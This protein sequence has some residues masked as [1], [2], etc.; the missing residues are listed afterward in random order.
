MELPNVLEGSRT[1][2]VKYAH[3]CRE[4]DSKLEKIK[5]SICSLLELFKAKSMGGTN[6]LSPEE[7]PE[8]L[9]L[10]KCLEKKINQLS[11]SVNRKDSD[12]NRKINQCQND[13]NRAGRTTRKH[14]RSVQEHLYGCT[15]F[16]DF[17]IARHTL[18]R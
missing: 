17:D 7:T 15:N 6:K 1:P 4:S 5:Q 10:L 11:D 2:T 18:F 9:S 8:H 14:D 12:I 3:T 16:K 13:V